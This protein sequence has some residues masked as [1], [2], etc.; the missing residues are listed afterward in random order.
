MA[1][2]RRQETLDGLKVFLTSEE[3]AA[4]APLSRDQ[5]DA[6]RPQVI[7]LREAYTGRGSKRHKDPIVN[8]V[9]HATSRRGEL[10]PGQ[11]F[12]ATLDDVLSELQDA[13]EPEAGPE[14]EEEVDEA[15]GERRPR[16]PRKHK[17]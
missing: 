13:E 4:L 16:G 2:A 11:T 7:A 15:S 9:M 6:M 12:A 1:R 17:R 14:A 10:K 5:V 3:A 8:A